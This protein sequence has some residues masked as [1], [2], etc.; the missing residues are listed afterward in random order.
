MRHSTSWSQQAG[1]CGWESPPHP[2]VFPLEEEAACVAPAFTAA[3]AARQAQIQGLLGPGQQD[4]LEAALR[5]AAEMVWDDA[6]GSVDALAAGL[7]RIGYDVS[8]A[9]S[10]GGA[11]RQLRHRF[12]TVALGA[13]RSLVVDPAF[14][15]QFELAPAVLEAAGARGTRYSSLLAV[16]PPLVVASRRRLGAAT[17]ILAE[18]ME[19]VFAAAGMSVPPWRRPVSLLSKWQAAVQAALHAAPAS[20]PPRSMAF[21]G[22]RAGVERSTSPG[23][24]TGSRR[25]L[26]WKEAPRHQTWPREL[27][28]SSE[29]QCDR[30]DSPVSV[31]GRDSCAQGVSVQDL[32]DRLSKLETT[33]GD[34]LKA[35]WPL[36]EVDVRAEL[37]AARSAVEKVHRQVALLGR[38]QEEARIAGEKRAQ[39]LEARQAEAERRLASL[40]GQVEELA[41]EQA[42][43]LEE[44]QQSTKTTLSEVVGRI[45]D[46]FEAVQGALDEAIGSRLA[47]QEERQQAAQL[48]Q[49]S[50]AA[51]RQW[52]EERLGEQ[53][54]A[55][56]QL[57]QQVATAAHV[58]DALNR[59]QQQWMMEQL[60]S[61]R[62]QATSSAA[63]VA[64]V[65]TEVAAV[66]QELQEGMEAVRVAA[67][68]GAASAQQAAEAGVAAA[69]AAAEQGAA[70]ARQAAEDAAAA[71]RRAG[72]EG[73]AAARQ[74]VDEA[75]SGLR[76][77]VA[78]QLAAT[79]EELGRAAEAQAC[80]HSLLVEEARQQSSGLAQQTAEL[81]ARVAALAGEQEQQAASLAAGLQQWHADLQSQVAEVSAA[82]QAAQA[83]SAEAEAVLQRALAA[84]QQGLEHQVAAAQ[85]GLEQQVAAAQQDMAVAGQALAAKFDEYRAYAKHLRK[86]VHALQAESGAKAA[87][88]GEVQA[89][90]A[91]LQASGKAAASVG[92]ALQGVALAAATHG[93]PGDR[94]QS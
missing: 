25:Q 57:G 6:V 94:V 52:A 41:A 38:D 93:R 77:D 55:V 49:E 65:R 86:E 22:A 78:E 15:E 67:K 62:E 21:A 50:L 47:E 11:L 90:A 35:L 73:A 80:A 51:Q 75:A 60:E 12:A 85:R 4:A 48:L 44:L 3:D 81:E 64:E 89:L 18:E 31:L 70:A 14:R 53:A 30:E 29:K 32:A 24:G 56:D 66:Q 7:H 43:V 8:V 13:S 39:Q 10:A 17:A 27:E 9:T 82:L 58:A 26:T 16:V 69:K 45:A 72:D 46:Q 87:L 76:A 88:H 20:P 68:E 61:V 19:G 74:A 34:E 42:V 92:A 84:W 40:A 23:A 91:E 5:A 79:R 36:R 37:T 28:S 83:R 63:A 54:A 71:V 1:V 59:S 33:V 2:L